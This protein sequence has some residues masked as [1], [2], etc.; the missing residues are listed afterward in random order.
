MALYLVSLPYSS[1]VGRRDH[2]KAVVVEADSS[3]IAKAL[4][5]A[6]WDGDGDWS[7]EATATEIA[8]GV[9]A[10]MTGFVYRIRV[11]GEDPGD[12]D[13]VDLTYTAGAVTVDQAGTAIAAA[14]NL[15][16]NV[17]GAAYDTGTNILIIA[18]GSG[19][20][21]LGDRTVSVTVTPPNCVGPLASLVSTVVDEG[22]STDDLTVVLVAPTAIPSIF[23]EI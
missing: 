12:P 13:A 23:A 6:R 14:L 9:A 16:D 11:S 22:V 8:T 17:A 20:D 10:D 21:D 2:T 15:L 4:V 5:A 7:V 1:G 3:A 18:E 19:T